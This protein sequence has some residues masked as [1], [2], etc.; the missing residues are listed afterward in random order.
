MGVFN[1]PGVKTSISNYS[2]YVSAASSVVVGMV[3]G[4]T[5]G[6]V[7][8]PTVITSE[9]NFVSTF[10]TPSLDN[11]GQA[12]AIQF[13]KQGNA[14]WYVRVTDGTDAVATVTVPDSSAT[15]VNSFVVSGG[16][17]GS[18]FNGWQ[19]VVS[20]VNTTVTPS[21]FTVQI[22]N[23]AG[24]SIAIFN[25]VSMYS[26][27]TTYLPTVVSNGGYNFTVTDPN[28]GSGSTPVAG[29]YTLSGGSDG[30][31]NITSADVIGTGTTGMQA[32][33]NNELYPISVL[34][35]PG[36]VDYSVISAAVTLCQTRG[37]CLYLV[38]T[39]Q[40]LSVSGVVDW[41]NGTG[42]YASIMTALNSEYAALYWPWVKFYDPY[43]A[44][45]R[46]SP[47]SGWISG[48]FAYNDSVAYPWDAPAGLSRG[49]LTLP[50]AIE[51]SASRSDRAQLQGS[52]NIVNPII[53]ITNTGLVVWGQKTTLRQQSDLNRV[54]VVR[55]VNYVRTVIEKVSL[56]LVFENNNLITWNEWVGMV[57]PFLSQIQNEGGLYAFSVV[58]DASVVTASDIQAHYLPGNVYLQPQLDAE[59]ID[60]GFVLE[61]TGVS[62]S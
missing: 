9:A 31:T 27:S 53:N 30:I 43:N 54:N 61:P 32:F 14:L 35:T 21:T 12:A 3:G 25:G 60:I 29:T 11:F 22:L 55:M 13:L 18:G 42:T 6:V 45:Y 58:M 46:W 16:S 26:T 5:M 15:P 17:S 7:N 28:S 19:A 20:N 39:P 52:G 4:A 62:F 44:T 2:G 23:T 51:Y 48:V 49:K 34:A 59:Y 50:V 36:F 38:D 1:S 40:G 57:T 10:G 41:S 24:S 56:Q 33:T 37:D 8:T 47:P